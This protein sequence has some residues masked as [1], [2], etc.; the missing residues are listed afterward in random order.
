MSSW[1][2]MPEK[3]CEAQPPQLFTARLDSAARSQQTNSMQ[4]LA[5]RSLLGGGGE[6]ERNPPGDVGLPRRQPCLSSLQ[7]NS[8]PDARYQS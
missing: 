4:A 8:A 1:R 2:V 6:Q 5:S 3:T 7:Q